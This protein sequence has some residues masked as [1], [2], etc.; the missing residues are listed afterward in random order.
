MVPP[1]VGTHYFSKLPILT[2]RSKRVT[3]YIRD[4]RIPPEALEGDLRGI[5]TE[6]AAG[7]FAFQAVMIPSLRAV[8]TAAVVMMLARR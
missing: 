6:A 5:V 2:C 1:K 8:A 7:V 4:D 3:D